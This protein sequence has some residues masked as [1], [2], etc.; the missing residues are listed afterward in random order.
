MPTDPRQV[1]P[2]ER[3]RAW[4]QNRVSSRLSGAGIIYA[5]PESTPGDGNTL[6]GDTSGERSRES[7]AR[8]L[9][10]GELPVE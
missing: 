2:S 10:L 5:D 8:Q 4:L 6:G 1:N 3:R 7:S 9:A